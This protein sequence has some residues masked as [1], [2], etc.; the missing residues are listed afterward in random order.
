M[1]LRG[2][3]SGVG[4]L[5]LVPLLQTTGFDFGGGT[6]DGFSRFISSLY[7][8]TGIPVTLPVILATY[9]GTVTVIALLGYILTVQTAVLQQKYICMLR[10][11]LFRALLQARWQFIIEH[12]MSDFTH[13]LSGQVQSVGHS[14]Y[15]MLDMFSRVILA[16]VYVLLSV[17]LSWQMSLLALGCSLFLFLTLTPLNKRIYRSGSRQLV[18]YKTVFHILTEQ[19]AGL[20]MIKSYAAEPHYADELLKAG[21]TL[22]NQHVR[23]TRFNALTRLIYLTG[24]AVS[25]SIL[26]YFAVTRLEVS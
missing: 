22:E 26:F 7:T 16:L 5:L 9:V 4:L 25:F 20:K 15:R 11:R 21:Q 6:G 23:M 17:L 24:A 10:D 19:L 14:A 8:T 12:R 13:S 1:L 2:V 18:G 3:T